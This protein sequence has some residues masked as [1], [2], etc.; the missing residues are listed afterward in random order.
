MLPLIRFPEPPHNQHTPG[1][2]V[3]Y[4]QTFRE[5]DRKY[6]EQAMLVGAIGTARLHYLVR[7]FG[8]LTHTHSSHYELSR[9]E[10]STL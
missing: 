1:S 4:L 2:M 7:A 8:T 10:E 3:Q 6:S 5:A 9:M